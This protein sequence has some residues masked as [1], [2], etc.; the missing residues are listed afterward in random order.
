MP[1]Q[2]PGAHTGRPPAA[3]AE[4]A[5]RANAAQMH[6]KGAI[7]YPNNERYEGD[8]VHGKR[9]GYGVYSY[10]DGGKFEGEWID[11]KV[12]RAGR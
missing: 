10:A 1:A 5:R 4:R 6:G 8:F 9:H 12:H 3:G 2:G 11:D 7:V